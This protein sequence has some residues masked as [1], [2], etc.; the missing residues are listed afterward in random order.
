MGA[1]VNAAVSQYR[2]EAELY[3]A[4]H[5]GTAGDIERYREVCSGAASVLELGCGDAR[6]LSQLVDVVRPK[7]KRLRAQLVGLDN[8]PG[9]LELARRRCAD[10]DVELG[11][12]D[13]SEF[14]LGRTFERILIPYSGF[15]CLDAEGKRACLAAVLRHLTPRGSLIFDVYAADTIARPK[16]S[17]APGSKPTR[18]R[19]SPFAFLVELEAAG[20]R[21]R[22]YEQLRHWTDE[23]R[24]EVIYEYRRLRRGRELSREEEPS[25]PRQTLEHHTLSRRALV[26]LLTA[27]GLGKV[28]SVERV[29]NGASAGQL[30]VTAARS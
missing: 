28:A 22:V 1:R 4:L 11:L 12:G 24:A 5:R 30:F 21:Y 14:D 23:R 16:R 7:R 6:V 27:A 10:L 25:A 20:H 13:M 3:V 9:M 18:P 15:W 8:H 19:V 29:P 17:R 26:T 2:R